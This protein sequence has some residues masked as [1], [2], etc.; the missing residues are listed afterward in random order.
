M[1]CDNTKVKSKPLTHTYT[2]AKKYFK[3]IFSKEKIFFLSFFQGDKDEK[4]KEETKEEE[5]K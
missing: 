5:K 2:V 4:E 1:T 3:I